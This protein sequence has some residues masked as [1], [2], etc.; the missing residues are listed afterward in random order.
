MY[1]KVQPSR[2]WMFIMTSLIAIA[3][4]TAYFAYLYTDKQRLINMSP[5][6][7]P[8][9]D[10]VINTQVLKEKYDVIVIGTDPEGITAAISA[11]RNGLSTLLVD[12]RDR[13]ILGGLMTIGW[14][15]SLDMNYDRSSLAKQKEIL[16]KGLF[17]EWYHTLEGDSFEIHTAANSFYALV[18]NEP[19][20][21]IWLQA[22]RIEPMMANKD[23]SSKTEHHRIIGIHLTTS[24]GDQL[25]IKASSVIDATQDA[26]IAAAAGVPFT[27][28]REDLGDPLSQMAVTLVFSLKQ[29]TPE[30]WSNIQYRLSHD[31][32]PYSGSNDMSAWGYIDMGKYPAQHVERLKMRG[33]NIGRQLNDT[34]LINSLQL[35]GV[36]I[37]DSQS[38]DEALAIAKHELP[39]IVDYLKVN[40][41]EFA[42][43]ELG[44]V[45]QELYV[46]E[47]RHMVGEYR[48][49]ILDILENRDQWDR[50]AFGSYPVD[51]Q[52]I[53]HTDTGYIVCAPDQYA[54]PF[55]SL[56]PLKV[57]GLLVVGRAAS[58]D[59]LP[60]G[61][62]RIIP[63]GMAKGQAAGVAA[64]ITHKYKITFREMSTI[65]EHVN[66]MQLM[67][68]QQGMELKPYTPKRYAFMDHQAYDGL[69]TVVSLGMVTGSY[70]N[71]FDL[72][73]LSHVQRMQIL[74]QRFL[75]TQPTLNKS[76]RL[77]NI[78]ELSSE[79]N[80][81][82]TLERA[83]HMLAQAVG[84]NA[85]PEHALSLLIER[86][87]IKEETLRYILRQDALT[88]ADTFLLFRDVNNYVSFYH[89]K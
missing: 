89:V 78:A 61:S 13:E 21:D 70:Q 65:R 25:S 54:I 10:K 51:I 6:Q 28:G 32:D 86:G 40:F 26:D 85:E 60:H 75:N 44:E 37:F 56:V 55:R 84:V 69:K 9:L 81:L 82:L 79:V 46:R 66:E 72:D 77:T 68:N 3:V 36:D 35:F 5:M 45:A 64:W 88:N 76:N 23:A 57:D 24:Q 7:N 16:N 47:T 49:H 41:P 27:M 50:V 34:V 4:V 63:N 2:T 19:L 39:L 31:G 17:T 30:V 22:E 1:P 74:T 15:N 52:R 29:V 20:I 71:E 12:G 80:I 18:R 83:S 33:L 42:S 48:L 67:L 38:V 14:L 73:Q 8:L 59:S 43:V 53:S 11:A 87:V 58:Y 62:A